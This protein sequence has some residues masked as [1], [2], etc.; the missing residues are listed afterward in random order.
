M[1]KVRGT[2]QPYFRYQTV[3]S[4]G[5]FSQQRAVGINPITN[6]TVII[7]KEFFIVPYVVKGLLDQ[8]LVFNFILQCIRYFI[9]Q[10]LS[11]SINSNSL[12]LSKPIS[13]SVVPN[14]I[15]AS[16]LF[17]NHLIQSSKVSLIGVNSNPV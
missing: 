14:F 8:A 12:D 13:A 3:N 1:V 16:R 4:E 9:N 6:C 11:L 10:P 5:L 7:A 2:F 17:L 15:F